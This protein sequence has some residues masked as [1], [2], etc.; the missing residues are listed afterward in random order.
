MRE[1]IVLAQGSEVTM[2][3]PI[4]AAE[5]EN[6]PS[7]VVQVKYSE[8]SSTQNPPNAVVARDLNGIVQFEE[9]NGTIDISVPESK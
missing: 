1:L 5:G 9:K 7:S 8:V 2:A 4:V 6:A 3:G